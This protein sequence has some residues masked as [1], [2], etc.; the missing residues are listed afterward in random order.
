MKNNN[1][2]TQ[3]ATQEADLLSYKNVR[4]IANRDLRD[5]GRFYKENK[6]VSF[7]FL[8]TINGDKLV[9]E[10]RNKNCIDKAVKLFE[11]YSRIKPGQIYYT[12][13]IIGHTNSTGDYDSPT[14]K[15]GMKHSKRVFVPKNSKLFHYL[16]E[17][18]WPTIEVI[19]PVINF[20]TSPEDQT[21]HANIKLRSEI[22]KN[23]ELLSMP[24]LKMTEKINHNRN[25][26]VIKKLLAEILE[27]CGVVKFNNNSTLMDRRERSFEKDT[28]DREEIADLIMEYLNY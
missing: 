27:D 18:F 15:I 2:F 9:E 7:P 4:S 6:M 17:D 19:D 20:W 24:M 28:K 13:G 12:K 25:K 14:L 5:L 1:N 8:T 23:T 11:F 26:K 22:E 21:A 10:L 16:T 3:I